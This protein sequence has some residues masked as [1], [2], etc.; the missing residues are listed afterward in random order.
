[1]QSF[2]INWDQQEQHIKGHWIAHKGYYKRI[3]QHEP[4]FLFFFSFFFYV[5]EQREKGERK[6]NIASL[7]DS[8]SSQHMQSLQVHTCTHKQNAE[9]RQHLLDSG[10]GNTIPL[11][12]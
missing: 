10:L 9:Q 6:K 5:D 12:K 7:F 3:F 1:M 11:D 4:F 8:D 2:R